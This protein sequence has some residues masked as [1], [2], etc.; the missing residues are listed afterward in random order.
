MLKILQARLQQYM[1]HELPDV[2]AGF[3]KAYY[4][5]VCRVWLFILTLQHRDVCGPCAVSPSHFFQQ[6]HLPHTGPP[7]THRGD[8]A[9]IV[10]SRGSGKHRK[11]TPFDSPLGVL[12]IS[13]PHCPQGPGT[14]SGTQRQGSST[15]LDFLYLKK[16]PFLPS[17]P[18]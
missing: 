8:D 18:A 17:V 13:R 15:N 4:T 12:S 10:L 3:R 14:E 6:H 1:N 7:I 11:P 2:Q 9:P 5:D 16:I